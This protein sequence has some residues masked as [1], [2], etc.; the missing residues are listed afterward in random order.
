MRFGNSSNINML[1]LP[2][3]RSPC[4]VPP[5]PTPTSICAGAWS[6]FMSSAAAAPDL[7]T[8]IAAHESFLTTT[9]QRSLLGGGKAE[10]LRTTL[11]ALLANC[12]GLAGHVN[13]FKTEVRGA[14]CQSVSQSVW[15]C[16]DRCACTCAVRVCGGG[17]HK[18]DTDRCWYS[19]C[20]GVRV[21]M[22]QPPT[23]YYPLIVLTH[24]TPYTL[25]HLTLCTRFAPSGLHRQVCVGQ[26]RAPDGS[27]HQGGRVGQGGDTGRGASHR[28]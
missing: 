26:P 17:G 27:K 24:L 21:S 1:A 7:D 5:P 19:V 23:L 4:C 25:S 8:L 28:P 15:G 12:M 16:L 14:V 20:Y 18:C 11:T 6:E 2:P 22:S 10:G 3:C 13:R 9:L